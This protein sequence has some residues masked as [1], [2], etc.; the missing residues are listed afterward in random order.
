MRAGVFH[1]PGDIRVDEVADPR[2]PVGGEA[3]VRVVRSSVCGSDL[4]AYRDISKGEQGSRTGHEFTGIV[5]A[6]GDG[7]TT[8]KPGDLVV[9]PFMWSCGTCMACRA[10][11]QTSCPSGQFVGGSYDAGQGER[12]LMPLAD[13]SLWKVPDGTPEALYDQVHLLSDVL[14][15]GY[16][17]AKLAGVGSAGLDGHPVTTAVVIGDGAVGL[18]GVV[19]AKLLGATTIVAVGHHDDR[20]EIARTLGATH[21]SNLRGKQLTTQIRELTDGG[22][23]AVLECVGV[24][25]ALMT[26]AAVVTG[27]GNVG[28]VGVPHGVEHA[29]WLG[30]LFGKNAALRSGVAPVR[31]Y[32]DEVGPAV[33]AGELDVSAIASDRYE[34]GELAGAYTAMDNRTAIKSILVVEP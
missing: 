11:L 33:C 2:D 16:H 28:S 15:T 31:A 9:S 34:L 30:M 25:G 20:L 3:V 5:E 6:V 10:G 4:W 7:V 17:A 27:G 21:T 8:I 22:A 18:S 1:G 26:A 12:V 19:G 23:P 29:A 32:M 13:G 24:T 14:L